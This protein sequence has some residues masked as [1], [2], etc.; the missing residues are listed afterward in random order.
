M[1]P[2]GTV[3][4]ITIFELG[5]I[6]KISDITFSTE[7]VSN[8]PVLSSKLVGVAITTKSQFS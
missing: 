4:L 2:S 7:V 3:D 5:D 1:K 6:L 8:E